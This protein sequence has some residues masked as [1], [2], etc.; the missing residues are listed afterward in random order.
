[1]P[2][3]VSID[4]N[5]LRIN[6][7]QILI[8]PSCIN[9]PTSPWKSFLIDSL[10]RKHDITT[11]K[12]NCYWVR[13]IKIIIMAYCDFF[14]ITIASIVKKSCLDIVV[15]CELTLPNYNKITIK[16]YAPGIR[17]IITDNFIDV[18]FLENVLT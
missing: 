2:N 4:Q 14:V 7:N 15:C 10:P 17:L 18:E 13:S 3:S 1:M 6:C 16:S 11:I 9:P 8:E 12:L 5:I